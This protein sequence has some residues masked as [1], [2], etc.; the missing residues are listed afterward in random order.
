MKNLSESLYKNLSELFQNEY[1]ELKKFTKN[2]ELDSQNTF[3]KLGNMLLAKAKKWV[4]NF[5]ESDILSVLVLSKTG[6][7]KTTLINAILNKESN[8]DNI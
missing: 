7:W 6:V 1:N 5:H 8:E 3:N 2:L 4:L